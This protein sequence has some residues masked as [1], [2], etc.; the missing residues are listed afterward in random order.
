VAAR[1]T[2][3]TVVRTGWAESEAGWFVA[4]VDTPPWYPLRG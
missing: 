2:T 3:N 1:V 4:V